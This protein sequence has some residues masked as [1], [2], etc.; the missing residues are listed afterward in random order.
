MKIA[1]IEAIPINIP[2]SVGAE[3][4]GWD[5][6]MFQG[7]DTVLVRVET[8]DGLVGWG[9]A[10]AYNCL[11]PVQAAVEDMVA[12]L[13]IGH[14]AADIGGLRHKLQQSLH[15]FGRYG[16][17]MFAI[18]GLDI[19]L[20]DIAGKAAGKPLHALRG[21]GA[22]DAIPAY[23]SLF[24]YIDVVAERTADALA[25]GYSH[26]KLHEITED[27]IAAARRT[28]GDGVPIMVDTNCP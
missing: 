2:M 12:P 4:A 15:L 14:D 28:A 5:V 16:I 17:T 1:S 25:R 8:D 19:A 18:S 6:D 9:D 23:A 7:L 13:A 10:Y 3:G 11:R 20:W 24:R 27:A 22:S 26:V 21:A